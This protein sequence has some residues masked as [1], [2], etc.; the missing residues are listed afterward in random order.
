MLRERKKKKERMTSEKKFSFGSN[1]DKKANLS[2]RGENI[3]RKEHSLSELDTQGKMKKVNSEQLSW[4]KKVS[5]NQV[6]IKFPQI[7]LV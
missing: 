7:A 2:M 5:E 3:S 4:K 1:Q 6:A